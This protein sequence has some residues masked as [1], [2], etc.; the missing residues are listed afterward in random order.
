[1]YDDFLTGYEVY[2]D[3]E[4]GYE[5]EYW[6]KLDEYDGEHYISSMGRVC[7][8]NSCYKKG[9]KFIGNDLSSD[10]YPNVGLCKNRKWNNK[11][12]HRLMAEHFI[13]N[14]DDYPLVRHLNDIKTD[15]RVENLAWG[16][17][18]D[19]MHDCIK[20]GHRKNW[21]V[22]IILI[23]CQT[24]EGIYFDS[25]AE[26]SRYLGSKTNFV[27]IA[28]STNTT[29]KGHRI[30]KASDVN[31]PKDIKNG[32]HIK[33]NFG[34]STFRVKNWPIKAYNINTREEII[35][36]NTKKAGEYFGKSKAMIYNRIAQHRLLNETWE[37]S[38]IKE[39]IY[40][41]KSD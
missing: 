1:M 20:N 12:I 24:G 38:R 23:E 18:S 37:L 19:N 40:E 3:V 21:Q 10:G 9:Y 35:F 17:F 39:D 34:K 14:P 5:D 6:S 16:T 36:E 32:D 28:L 27:H 4:P 41:H 13:P 11:K 22:P 33:E 15:N 8:I 25:C 29:A 30:I 2:G 31:L 26:A 7:S